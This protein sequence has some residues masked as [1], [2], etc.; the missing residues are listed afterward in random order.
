MLYAILLAFGPVFSAPGVQ[1]LAL[2]QAEPRCD[3]PGGKPAVFLAGG[4]SVA[5]GEAQRSPGKM[6]FSHR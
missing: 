6:S 2:G 3:S 1:A 4:Q 5:Q